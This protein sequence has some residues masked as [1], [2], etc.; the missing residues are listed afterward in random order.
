MEKWCPQ[1]V[2]FLCSRETRI[3]VKLV[4]N[5]QRKRRKG[6]VVFPFCSK[7]LKKYNNQD[8]LCCTRPINTSTCWWCTAIWATLGFKP[9]K[10]PAGS[11]GN[12]QCYTAI[13][14]NKKIGNATKESWFL[15][16]IAS[17]YSL[18]WLWWDTTPSVQI[19][20]SLS[21]TP[22][23]FCAVLCPWGQAIRNV[24]VQSVFLT[25]VSQM[26]W[27]ALI[28]ILPTSQLQRLYRNELKSK[29]LERSIRL[30]L[31]YYTPPLGKELQC[32]ATFRVSNSYIATN[33]F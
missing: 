11:V 10:I 26:V 25:T 22:G 27:N 16:G 15:I 4:L 12:K 6:T 17:L 14:G 28:W 20:L 2:G 29:L 24:E 30:L 32:D 1:K 33:S 5:G 7:G 9:V 19:F 13:W 8:A 21:P 18:I 23:L 31:I 3:S